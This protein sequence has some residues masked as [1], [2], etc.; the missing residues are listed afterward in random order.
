MLIYVLLLTVILIALL[1]GYNFFKKFYTDRKHVEGIHGPPEKFFFGHMYILMADK[2]EMFTR[3][4][5]FAKLYYPIYRFST[6]YVNI[7]NF[8]EPDDIELILSSTKHLTKSKIYMF[9]H[10]WLGTGLLTSTGAKW[11]KRRKILTP[12]FH[13][14]ILQQFLN[15]FNNETVKLVEK[16]DDECGKII[17]VVP[18]VTNF[19]LQSI[20][21][22]AMGLSTIDDSTRKKYKEAIYEIGRIFLSRLEK[23]WYRINAIYNMSKLAKK[24]SSVI[25]VLH[26]FS[27]NIIAEREKEI[28]S[29]SDHLSTYSKKKRLAMLDLLLS[30]KHDGAD[31]DHEGIREE[32]D[33]FMFEGH[34]T[35]SMGI[36]FLLLVLANLQDVQANVLDE[37]LSVLGP[38]KVPTYDDLQE[39]KYTE[40]CI[41]ETLRLFPSVPLISRYAGEEFV[42][43]TGYTIPKDT[44]MHIHIFDVHRNEKIYPDPLKFDPDRFL[45]EIANARHPFAYIPFSAGPRNCIGQRFALMEL[46]TVLCGVLRKFKLEKVDDMNDVE[47]RPDLVL[48]PMRDVKVKIL[49]RSLENS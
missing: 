11:H 44:V 46:K 48:R 5:K 36:S 4:R 37:I 38:T 25:K 19:T 33:T 22:T 1:N 32:V 41:K 27:N 12:A 16:L 7:I 31:I 47:F 8:L 17:D 13:F 15:I 9:L 29:I 10:N 39:L 21:E 18:P 49:P 3:A 6:L 28:T 35:T 2:D 23:P 42:T 30:A 43:K 34:D 40:R 24:E 26:D 45:P 20:A 14:S